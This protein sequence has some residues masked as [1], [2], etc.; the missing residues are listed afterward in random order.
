VAAAEVDG[1]VTVWLAESGAVLGVFHPHGTYLNSIDLSEDGMSILT[2]SDDQ[3]ARLFSC[4]TC[5]PIHDVEV[6]A[7]TQLKVEGIPND[8]REFCRSVAAG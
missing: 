8:L 5:G 4:S 2:G 6:A 1:A 3:T 7:C